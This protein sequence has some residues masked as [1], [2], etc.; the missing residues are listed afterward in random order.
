[1]RER[2]YTDE[3]A[4]RVFAQIQGFGE[5]GF[6]ESHA[7][8]F[9]LLVYISAWLKCHEPAAFTA[10]LLN[11]QPMGFYSPSQLVRD[12]REHGV[13]VRPVDVLKSDWDC[14]LE[15][16]VS[17]KPAIRLGLRLV[18]S[19]TH[20]GAERVVAMR[21]RI[22]VLQDLVRHAELDRGDLEALAAAG[23]CANLS[24]NRHQ[25]F[26]SVAGAEVELPL[27]PC[28]EEL[29]LPLLPVPT[30]GENLVADYRALG[31]TLGRHPLA[32][33]RSLFAL[34]EVSTASQLSNL[35][36]E[37]PVS[38]AGLVTMRQRP[39]TASGVTF[40]TLEDDT[41]YVNLI[42]WKRIGARY[43]RELLHSRLLEAEGY[44]QREGEV[45]H[46]IVERLHDRSAWLGRLTTRSRDFR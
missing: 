33:L 29:A 28:A 27:A 17:G 10:A 22:D 21:D 25:A 6:P 24:G 18:H 36:S 7:A 42:V 13:E 9:A 26:W 4:Q 14:T 39:G 2:G 20:A 40:V 23:A 16:T 37:S 8:S 5:Y 38:V 35:P 12:A 1:M 41:G 3:F 34:R 46:V 44:L 32:L 11:S 31:L 45:L 15:A 43:R 30:E 19:L